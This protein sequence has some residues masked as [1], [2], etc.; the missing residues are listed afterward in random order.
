MAE[1]ARLERDGDLGVLVIDNGPLNLFDR[2]L[3]S[4]ILRGLDEAAGC[5]A[6]LVRAEG[7]YFTGGVDVQVFKGLS[8]ADAAQL[9]A[10]LL[11]DH[12]PARG[13]AVP[14][15]RVACTGCASPPASSS[16]WPAT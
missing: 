8:E 12:A 10:D 2:D 1:G 6:L 3:V 4:G 11:A 15:A 5:R 13:A 9:T 7:E 16:R 14:D